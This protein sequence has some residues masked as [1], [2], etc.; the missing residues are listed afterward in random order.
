MINKTF[1]VRRLN[2]RKTYFFRSSLFIQSWDRS[3]GE[4]PGPP[5]NHVHPKEESGGESERDQIGKMSISFPVQILVSFLMDMWY[6]C[7]LVYLY[8]K[9]Q[10]F[11]PFWTQ[12]NS[13]MYACMYDWLEFCTCNYWWWGTLISVICNW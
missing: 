5:E 7:I 6:T 8:I 13:L 9:P 4:R 12:L 11:E 2:C 10:W 3:W 1:P